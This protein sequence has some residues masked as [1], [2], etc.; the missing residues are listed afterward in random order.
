MT[1]LQPEIF[2]KKPMTSLQPEIF[3][4][5]SM[6]SLQPEILGGENRFEISFNVIVALFRGEKNAA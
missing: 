4:K 6:T 3:L 2:L 1:S 5:K